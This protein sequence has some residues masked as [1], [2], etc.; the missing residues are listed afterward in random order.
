MSS[1]LVRNLTYVAVAACFLALMSLIYRSAKE[2]KDRKA[3][4]DGTE[5]T[6]STGDNS[7]SSRIYEDE[8]ADGGESA[9]LD[10]MS[11]TADEEVIGSETTG[12]KMMTPTSRE[13]TIEQDLKV[14]GS[15]TDAIIE[16][17]AAPTTGGSKSVGARKKTAP[18]AAVKPKTAA[19]VDTKPTAAFVGPIEPK[20]SSLVAK[21]GSSFSVIA[22]AFSTQ[23]AADV[24]KKTLATKG[25]K[26]A[27]VVPNGTTFRV[28]AGTFGSRKEAD[29]AVAKLKAGKISAFVAP[30]VAAK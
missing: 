30:L 6:P 1:N 16:D 2:N 28:S 23:A 17:D 25:F 20:K 8:G 11:L 3:A 19:T 7:A 29:S 9:A 27:K 4:L 18:T 22:G 5:I 10:S 15:S 13:S 24:Q 12:G 14:T 21:G 26:N